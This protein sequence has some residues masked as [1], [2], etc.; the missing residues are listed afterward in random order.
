MKFL[1]AEYID[2]FNLLVKLIVGHGG[3]VGHST[4]SIC[5]YVN[6]LRSD[7]QGCSSS[8]ILYNAILLTAIL[9][10]LTMMRKHKADAL[11]ETLG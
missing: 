6:S 9:D 4:P 2:L 3:H 8:F 5:V 7:L 11:S 10:T 1:M